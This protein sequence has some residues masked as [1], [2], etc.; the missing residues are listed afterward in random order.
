MAQGS[1]T[2]LEEMER[3]FDSFPSSTL[4]LSLLDPGGSAQQAS[5]AAPPARK[6]GVKDYLDRAKNNVGPLRDLLLSFG[7]SMIY[8]I[9]YWIFIYFVLIRGNIQIGSV[10]FDASK[11]NLLVSIFS[12]FA[13]ILFD[14]VIR[15]LFGC[16]RLGFANTRRGLSLVNF[17][18]MGA[19]SSWLSTLE[20]TII[21]WIREKWRGLFSLWCEL[22]LA[23]P[24]MGLAFGSVLKFQADFLYYFVSD[25]VQIPIFAGLVPIDLRTLITIPA[26]DLSMYF[27][28]WTASLLSNTRYA[29]DIPFDACGENCRSLILPGGIEMARQF[30]SSLNYTIFDN[31]L[32]DNAETVRIENAPGLILTFEALRSDFLFN[33]DSISGDCVFG[34]QMINNTLQFCVKQ[35]NQSLAVGWAVCPQEL[36]DT[37]KCN[38]DMTWVSGSLGWSTNLTAYKLFTTT[39]YDRQNSSII[40]VQ[41]TRKPELM[42]LNAT[43]YIAIANRVLIPTSFESEVDKNNI[44]ALNYFLTW[45]HRTYRYSFPDDRNTLITTLHNFLA[46]PLQFTVTA[47]QFSNYTAE[48][49]GLGS[50]PMPN[51][52]IT[53]A[54]SGRSSSRLFIQP[55]AG[56]LFIAGNIVL[57]AFIFGGILFMLFQ[58]T[59]LPHTTGV[60]EL[61]VVRSLETIRCA[62][63]PQRTARQPAAAAAV[64]PLS[65]AAE[66]LNALPLDYIALHLTASPPLSSWARILYLRQWRVFSTR[67]NTRDGHRD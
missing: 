64:R 66:E 17:L 20:F 36:Y 40:D 22:R 60:E 6:S 41:T 44:N 18:G 59:K 15:D 57:L 10:L 21:K 35:A 1:V 54:T 31:G 3:Q 63:R 34:G 65:R 51:D 47:V 58:E 24:I 8:S 45:A 42:F 43:E 46:V 16:L 11:T 48:Q 7:V 30:N 2:P 33:P 52:T 28:I 9:V 26:S 27:A 4:Q 56:W 29:V 62:K 39:S 61:D 55:W 23:I 49:L 19:S 50:F 13:A 38:N 25:H 67:N 12:Q 37:K 53:V 32:L 14:M 5:R